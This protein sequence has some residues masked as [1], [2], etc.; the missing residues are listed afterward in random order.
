MYMA[1]SSMVLF[2]GRLLGGFVEV[3]ASFSLL[4]FPILCNISVYMNMTFTCFSRIKKL[5]IK[6]TKNEW[7]I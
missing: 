2:G 6:H 3:F 5:L 7:N 4:L 1:Q